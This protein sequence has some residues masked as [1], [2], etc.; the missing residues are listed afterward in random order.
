MAIM[1]E[2][3]FRT[4]ALPPVD[5]F[6]SWY[7]LACRSLMGTRI[8]S[9]NMADFP[10][11]VRMLNLGTVQVSRE[12]FPALQVERTAKLIRQS[13][14]DEIHLAFF[15]SGNGGFTR[16]DREIAVT[17]QHLMLYDT[18]RPFL[19]WSTPTQG[20]TC[21]IM[22]VQVQRVLLP[23]PLNAVDRLAGRRLSRSGGFG[24]LVSRCL[25]EVIT[26]PARYR[27]DDAP[28]LATLTLDLLTALLAH[29]LN[30]ETSLPTET[31]QH[32][33]MARIHDFIHRNLADPALSPALIATAH[34]I[35]TRY[36]HRI[37]HNHGLTVGG[38]IRQR[39]LE[40]CHHDLGDPQLRSQPIQAIAARWGFNDNAHF[41]RLFR[42]TYG[43][44]PRDYRHLVRPTADWH[45]PSTT[46]HPDP[47][48]P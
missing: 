11:T 3:E 19:A 20:N 7:E 35:S 26:N 34:H 18:W 1:I 8:R 10:A 40:R 45:T 36:L 5:R 27:P 32:A 24:G 30:S 2:T 48:D 43:I 15:L 37:F 47:T 38:L 21:T 29:E 22:R 41:S 33:L 17:T 46:V 23:L 31:R 12:T 39:R 4:E 28:R 6:D 14:P 16:A 42:A 9:D 13:D 44:P 25:R